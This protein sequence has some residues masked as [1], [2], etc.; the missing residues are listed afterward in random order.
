MHHAYIGIGT[1]IEPRHSRIM[2]GV[3]AL[4]LLGTVADQS[5][6]Y[7]TTPMGYTEQADFLNAAVHLTTDLSVEELHSALK[8][9]ELHLGRQ[10]RERW[11]ER[12]IDFDL[13]LFNDEVVHTPALTVP[14]PE[15]HHRAFVLVPLAQIAP[16]LV[17]PILKKTVMQ[18]LGDLGGMGDGVHVYSNPD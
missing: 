2:Q 17:H 7:E 9:L 14:H 15:L 18:S 5:E 6:V 8:A 3:E 16:N 4:T 13:L 11:H 10:H 1:N 12:E